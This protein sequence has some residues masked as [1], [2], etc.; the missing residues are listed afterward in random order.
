MM[1]GWQAK[2]TAS[3]NDKNFLFIC[4]TIR[5][6][7]QAATCQNNGLINQRCAVDIADNHQNFLRVFFRKKINDT[8]CHPFDAFLAETHALRGL[9]RDNQDFISCV[10]PLIPPEF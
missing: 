3:L 8:L 5:Y 4:A 9:T 7:N 10:F 2:L 1:T 6:S